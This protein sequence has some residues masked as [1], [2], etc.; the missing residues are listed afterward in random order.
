MQLN[1]LVQTSYFERECAVGAESGQT[2]NVD[3]QL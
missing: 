3:E 1:G 2:E